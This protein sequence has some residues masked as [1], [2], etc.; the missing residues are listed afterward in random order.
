MGLGDFCKCSRV[1]KIRGVNGSLLAMAKMAT[2]TAVSCLYRQT[3]SFVC[4][5]N[6]GSRVASLATLFGQAVEE[7]REVEDG[8]QLGR[9]SKTS[10]L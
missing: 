2:A 5:T 1:P 10:S 7:W 6:D 8:D 9:A 4:S 3:V